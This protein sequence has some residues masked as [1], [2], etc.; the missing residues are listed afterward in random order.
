MAWFN[1]D[2]FSSNPFISN[3]FGNN[4]TP[5][6]PI[7]PVITA[8]PYVTGPAGAGGFNTGE[9]QKANY[10]MRN[11]SYIQS[12]MVEP[13]SNVKITPKNLQSELNKVLNRIESIFDEKE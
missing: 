5:I 11:N 13:P 8:I 6:P 3:W 12:T 4:S 7:P 2:W 10:F 9:L 1:S